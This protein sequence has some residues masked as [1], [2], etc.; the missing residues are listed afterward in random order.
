[1]IF[2]ADGHFSMTLMRN[3]P[4]IGAPSTDP[5]PEDCVPVWYCSYF[6]TYALSPGTWTTTVTGTNIPAY[7]G[8]QQPR[9]YR[10]AGDRLLIDEKY[11]DAAGRT[12]TAERVLRRLPGG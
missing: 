8:T 12:V 9:H 4:D 5:D 1:M 3:P 7:L 10:I 6:G 2:T 11:E